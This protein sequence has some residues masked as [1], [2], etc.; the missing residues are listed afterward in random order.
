MRAIRRFKAI[1]LVLGV[2]YLIVASTTNDIAFVYVAVALLSLPYL[3]QPQLHW[4]R[5]VAT[6]ASLLSLLAIAY[7]FTLQLALTRL[8]MLGVSVLLSLTLCRYLN[9]QRVPSLLGKSATL[10]ILTSLTFWMIE[11]TY[12]H[13][14]APAQH[15][16]LDPRRQS[17]LP[18]K[19]PHS[20]VAIALSGG[21][22]RAV[23]LHAGVLDAYEQLGLKISIVSA[24]SGGAIVG[25]YYAAGGSPQS[26]FDGLERGDYDLLRRIMRFPNVARL[27]LN[28]ELPLL[29]IRLN[30]FLNFNRTMVQAQLLQDVFLHDV[31][32]KSVSGD[33]GPKL[34]VST[35]DL[36]HGSAVGFTYKG[37]MHRPINAAFQRNDYV[38]VVEVDEALVTKK[39][40]C[41]PE[42]HDVVAASG[43]F[44]GAFKPVN[45]HCQLYGLDVV[46]QFLLADGG[47]LDNLGLDMLIAAGASSVDWRADLVLVSD[48]GSFLADLADIPIGM[49]RK[50]IEMSSVAQTS[51]AVDVVYANGA[52]KRYGARTYHPATVLLSPA[53]F[54][55]GGEEDVLSGDWWKVAGVEF[56]DMALRELQAIR[57]QYGPQVLGVPLTRISDDEMFLA[58]AHIPMGLRIANRTALAKALSA[59]CGGPTESAP[60]YGG[61]N[62]IPFMVYD[63]ANCVVTFLR[64]RTLETQLTPSQANQVFRLGAYL[65]VLNWRA[66]VELL[67]MVEKYRQQGGKGLDL[68]SKSVGW[69]SR[70][71]ENGQLAFAVRNIGAG[72]AEQVE[73]HTTL[74]GNLVP[75]KA[76]IEGEGGREGACS[77]SRQAVTCLLRD[78]ETGGERVITV[79]VRADRYLRVGRELGNAGK[80]SGVVAVV[81]SVSSANPS[82]YVSE[83][84]TRELFLIH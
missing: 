76:T 29:G 38:N 35:A 72:V 8:G 71:G 64:V 10:I 55:Q 23:F 61:S 17:A 42:L 33:A 48:A 7:W 40:N 11:S 66:S 3:G 54:R 58:N 41:L 67:D 20:R 49:G 81:G 83:V 59:C 60:I 13:Y 45:P 77:I 9:R 30:P 6:V 50:S 22:Y 5:A 12:E 43:A 31:T 52:N 69:K 26:L 28:M 70:I 63:F 80:G 84:S 82:R 51:R 68:T 4:H 24:V 36:I 74:P 44:P 21:G 19:W 16:P 46:G 65:A 56:Y 75:Q 2:T 14:M 47:L 39:T 34:L 57:L 32:W 15:L 25:S 37:A 53:T 78:M 73:F 62:L 79:S 1:F 27:A 18:D